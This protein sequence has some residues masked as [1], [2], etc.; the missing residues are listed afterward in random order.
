M[1]TKKDLANSEA[2]NNVWLKNV[3]SGATLFYVEPS[4]VYF[5]PFIAMIGH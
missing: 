5:V 4:L 2:G 3:S 1:R